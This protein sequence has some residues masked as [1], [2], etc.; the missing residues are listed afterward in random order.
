M[1]WLPAREWIKRLRAEGHDADITKLPTPC[2]WSGCK[3]SA[4][5][6]FDGIALCT[7]HLNDF[8]RLAFTCEP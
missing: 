5:I 7:Q 2:E 8:M 6:L 3:E 4:T 1:I